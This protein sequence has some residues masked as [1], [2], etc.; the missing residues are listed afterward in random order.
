[1]RG[2][3]PRIQPERN[4]SIDGLPGERASTPVFDGLCPAMTMVG[5][6]NQSAHFG[7]SPFVPQGMIGTLEVEFFGE[8]SMMRS[9]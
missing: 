2:L 7:T 5:Y 8:P 4:R 6:S 1:M 9:E 3:D